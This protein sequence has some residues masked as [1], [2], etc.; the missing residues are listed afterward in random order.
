MILSEFLKEYRKGVSINT[1]KAFSLRALAELIGVDQ[2]RLQKWEQGTGAPKDETDRIKVR[3]FFD[4]ELEGGEISEV[5]LKNAIG[6]YPKAAKQPVFDGSD[7]RHEEARHVF[8]IGKHHPSRLSPEEYNEAF[9]GWAGV[10]M[11][12]V[13]V[14]ASFVEAYRD[15]SAYHPQYYLYDPRFK[16]CNF[17]AIITGDSMYPEIRHGDFVV[18]QEILDK[19]F[20]VF[21]DI[22]YVVASNGLET[23]KYINVD[24]N[25][26]DNLL[27]VPRNDSISPSP[28]PK[29]MILRLFKMRGVVRGY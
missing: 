12:N 18:C 3:N 19:R 14:T 20:I 8:P 17:G 10:P 11:Y 2:W 24:P 9:K 4:I 22:Y 6:R 25:D 5:I 7:S 1:G 28:I 15:E 23:C 16:D 21:G 29:D 27:L 13:P 26:R